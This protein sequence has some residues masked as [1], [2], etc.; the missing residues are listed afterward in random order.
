MLPLVSVII[1]THKRSDFIVRAINSVLNQSYKNIEIIVVDDNNGNDKFR[2]KTQNALNKF[3]IKKQIIYLKHKYNLGISAA[4][5]TGIKRAK[6][7]YIAFLDDDDEFLPNKTKDQIN[8]FNQ[9][10]NKV[11]LVY[12][13]YLEINSQTGKK[14]I[15]RPKLKKNIQ[16]ILGL[17]Y[18][19]PP[20]MVMFTKNA[21]KKI[22]KFDVNL[23]HKEDID[24]YFRLSQY[25]YVNY[26]NKIIIKY[27]IHPGGSSKNNKDRLVKMLRFI[28]KH[29]KKMKKPKTRWS[30]LNERLGDLY[31]LNSYRN[32]ALISYFKAY[33]DRPYRIKLLIKIF[34][35]LLRLKIC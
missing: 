20:S 33:R 34:I 27:Y 26:T 7:K 24:Y 25:F 22:G 17:N 23:N 3:I 12:G 13:A 11:G 5:N 19:G 21:L 4:R 2:K 18:L 16:L 14:R 10:D 28:K 31:I 1:P 15:I 30:E 35:S 32:K 9:S 29:C 6:G 8:I